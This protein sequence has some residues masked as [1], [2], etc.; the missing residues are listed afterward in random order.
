MVLPMLFTVLLITICMLPIGF[1]PMEKHIW[2]VVLWL[3]IRLNVFGP[4]GD[5]LIRDTEKE[6]IYVGGGAGMAP[7]RSHLA[8]LFETQKNKGKSVTVMVQGH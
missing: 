2:Q 1:V 7:L 5:F 6:M 4:Y 3:E 8:F